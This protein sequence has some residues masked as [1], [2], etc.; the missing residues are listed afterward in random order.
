MNHGLV[1]PLG[2]KGSDGVVHAVKDK[3]EG[4]AA[5][6]VM[7]LVGEDGIVNIL[8]EGSSKGGRLCRE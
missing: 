3:K 5:A 1:G 2:K 7:Y 6:K 8:G 4:A